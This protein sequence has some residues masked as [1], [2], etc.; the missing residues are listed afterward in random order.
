MNDILLEFLDKGPAH[1][2]IRT[3]FDNVAVEIRHKRPSEGTSTV[4]EELE[5]MR[6]VQ[7]DILNYMINPDW[8]SPEWPAG[9]WPQKRAQLSDDAWQD[10]CKGFCRNLE[11]VVKFVKETDLDLI[12]PIIHA[13]RHTYLREILLIIDHNA[14]HAGKIIMIRKYFK[15]WPG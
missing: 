9:Y 11:Q 7:E 4:W 2:P 13:P 1:V 6:L 12:Q 14:Y 15:N 5:H 3:S 8:V 10:T